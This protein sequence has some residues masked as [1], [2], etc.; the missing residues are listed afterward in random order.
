MLP[1][2]QVEEWFWRLILLFLELDLRPLKICGTKLNLFS[3]CFCLISP[4]LIFQSLF[5]FASEYSLWERGSLGLEV[6]E[7]L[8]GVP[9]LF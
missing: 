6:S 4:C 1:F 2:L 3:S 8:F 5:Y 7:A 9:L